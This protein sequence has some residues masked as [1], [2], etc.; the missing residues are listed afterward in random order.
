MQQPLINNNDVRQL[1][2]EQEKTKRNLLNNRLLK[3]RYSYLKVDPQN[4]ARIL[5]N[6][7]IEYE[8]IFDLINNEKDTLDLIND[9][10]THQFPTS[11][12]TN[13]SHLVQVGHIRPDPSLG[14]GLGWNF[15]ISGDQL[16]RGAAYNAFVIMKKLLD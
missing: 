13:N 12:S 3:R 1:P 2:E 8:D 16:L 14:E 5:Q 7:P 6:K 9:V 15:W 10:V 4:R 11:I